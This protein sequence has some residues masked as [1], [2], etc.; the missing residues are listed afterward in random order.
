MSSVNNIGLKTYQATY[1]HAMSVFNSHVRAYRANSRKRHLCLA[2]YW[3][4]VARQTR[5]FVNN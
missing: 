4:G 2:F 3:F 1:F 5:L